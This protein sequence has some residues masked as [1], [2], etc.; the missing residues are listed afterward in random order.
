MFL[1]EIDKAEPSELDVQ[2]IVD[3]YG[4]HKHPK[5]KTWLAARPRWP[6]HFVPVYS[7]WLNQVERFFAL[8][9]T[10]SIRRVSFG[11]VR[12]LIRRID[13]F[14]SRYNETCKSFMWTASANS[15]LEKLHS[16]V[17]GSAARGTRPSFERRRA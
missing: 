3:N 14:V 13:Q 16:F 12:Q 5:V 4:S 2:C 8:I 10:K 17:C 6:M 9:T 1:R 7:S 15:I 11:S